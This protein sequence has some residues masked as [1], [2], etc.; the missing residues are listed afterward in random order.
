M[1]YISTIKLTKVFDYVV[2][3]F[4]GRFCKIDDNEQKQEK[5]KYQEQIFKSI[6]GV[7]I[8]SSSSSSTSFSFNP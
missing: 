7:F 3:N 4:I 5:I 8:S 6:L 2:K 1:K